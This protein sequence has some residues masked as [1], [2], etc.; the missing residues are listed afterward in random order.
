MYLNWEQHHLSVGRIWF[1]LITNF[2]FWSKWQ[3]QCGGVFLLVTSDLWALWTLYALTTF[4][5][6]CLTVTQPAIIISIYCVDVILVVVSSAWEL[7]RTGVRRLDWNLWCKIW[8]LGSS[9]FSTNAACLQSYL[10]LSMLS[11]A[12]VDWWFRRDDQKIVVLQEA[13][14]KFCCLMF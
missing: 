7:R 3:L 13:C 14:H 1:Y 5:A 6:L 9:G 2:V 11:M 4:T 12:A 10:S 8:F